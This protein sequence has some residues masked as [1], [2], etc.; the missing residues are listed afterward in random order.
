ME[1]VDPV[2]LW[3]FAVIPSSIRKLAGAAVPHRFAGEI[4]GIFVR[5]VCRQSSEKT[6]TEHVGIMNRALPERDITETSSAVSMLARQQ[7]Y[8]RAYTGSHLQ[9]AWIVQYFKRFQEGEAD[10]T[11]PH[12][13]WGVSRNCP[14]S[15]GE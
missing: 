4:D 9:I 2:I 12:D 7:L 6:G 11:T 3:F 5:H 14:G 15:C 10:Q 13:G 8:P 1:V